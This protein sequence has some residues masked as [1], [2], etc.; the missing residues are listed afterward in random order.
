MPR[1]VS[2]SFFAILLTLCLLTEHI[3]YQRRPAN[4]LFEDSLRLCQG[5]ALRPIEGWSTDRLATH[6]R[7]SLPLKSWKVKKKAAKKRSANNSLVAAKAEEGHV[8]PK[9]QRI[10]S[11]K[12]LSAGDG[13]IAL[14]MGFRVMS[15][16]CERKTSP[17]DVV[18]RVGGM[19]LSP[20]DTSPVLED[21]TSNK[22]KEG[23][24]GAFHM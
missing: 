4:L 3:T 23:T 14:A 21:D 10:A 1:L 22:M 13:L 5:M 6:A 24:L 15:T 2:L 11:S 17:S 16:S 12:E 18:V 19:G 8:T 20:F 7:Y 9:R